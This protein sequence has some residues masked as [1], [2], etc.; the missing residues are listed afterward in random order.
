[1][2]P[3]ACMILSWI[4]FCFSFAQGEGLQ[5]APNGFVIDLVFVLLRS[6]I[7]EN[8]RCLKVLYVCV[9]L[10]KLNRASA[11]QRPTRGTAGCLPTPMPITNSRVLLI[12]R[13][14]S[15]CRV[16]LTRWGLLLQSGGGDG[17][18]TSP[19]RGS[20]TGCHRRREG[21]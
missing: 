12:V 3:A 13:C 1:M 11:M 21:M 9:K 14:S 6:C 10:L 4:C 15:G 18:K 17:R 2:T 7:L 20:G 19:R 16:C 5:M 8:L